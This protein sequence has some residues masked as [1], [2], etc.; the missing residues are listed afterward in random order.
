MIA[1][2]CP[3]ALKINIYTSLTS[4]CCW[5]SL[6]L[7]VAVSFCESPISTVLLRFKFC[8]SGRLISVFAVNA[9][10]RLSKSWPTLRAPQYWVNTRPKTEDGWHSAALF[11]QQVAG[12]G[13]HDTR[14]SEDEL[15]DEWHT[16]MVMMSSV[17]RDE[18]LSPSLEVPDLLFRLFHAQNVHLQAPRPITDTCRCSA[19][20]VEQ[21][22]GGLAAEALRDMSDENGQLHV[23][24]EF[25]K[26]TR[27]YS[28]A[29]FLSA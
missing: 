8:S 28:M 1:R 23:S 20:K 12:E 2:E 13:G 22:L 18:L 17:T 26:I 24:C 16:A 11:L 9:I 25:C 15:A 4:V 27:S 5:F 14:L 10:N 21:V 29:E 3:R 7:Y 6:S 19:E